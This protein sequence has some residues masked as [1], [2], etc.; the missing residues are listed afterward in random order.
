MR[1]GT[2][3]A[4]APVLGREQ[5]GD[6]RG[7]ERVGG[8]PV[9]GV[10]G[11]EHQLAAHRSRR[12]R[13]RG[14]RRGLRVG[15][16]VEV[17]HG[18]VIVIAAGCPRRAAPVGP[19]RR[20]SAA[21]REVGVVCDVG[22]TR[23][24]RAPAP[25]AAA[26][27]RRR[28][29]CRAAPPGRSSRAAVTSTPRTTSRPSAPPPQRAAAGRGRPPRGAPRAP[30]GTYGGLETTTSTVPS[31]SGSSPV[32]H[33]AACSSTGV[34]GAGAGGG[35]A[36]GPRDAPPGR[37]RRR[38]RAA[39]GRSCGDGQRDRARSRA[40]VDDE[41]RGRPAIRSS[42][43]PAAA[44]SPGRGMN[45]P[46]PTARSRSGTARAGEVLQ[47]HAGRAPGDQRPVPLRDGLVD[48]RHHQQPRRAARRAR[49]PRSSSA[50]TRGLATPA[51][52]SR[53]SASAAPRSGQGWRPQ[54]RPP[55]LGARCRRRAARAMTAS[56][57][58]SSTWSRL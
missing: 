54:V 1:T 15:A 46:G 41:R 5:P 40:Q 29:R 55:P 22:E 48:Q 24:A 43:T 31:S 13:H 28:A 8:H 51:A 4:A 6:G 56:R 20:A 33:V 49:A 12:P 36:A 2:G 27:R 18:A 58:P 50:S 38:A 32:G 45:T 30:S 23:R 10:G 44:R 21:G 53:R 35:V 17:G 52:A 42:T 37:A 47:R 57:S 9:D 34:P 26:L 11:Q 39:P 16:V 19:W 25:A 14:R 3:M 7:G